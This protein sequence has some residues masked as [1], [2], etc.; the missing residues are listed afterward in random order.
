MIKLLRTQSNNQ[1][2]I[3]LV[4]YLDTELAERDGEE[5]SFYDQFNKIDQI[6]YVVIAYKNG[7]SLGCGAIKPYRAGTMEIKR[8]FVLNHNRG[9]GIASKILSELENWA[10]ELSYKT[11]ILETGKKQPEAIRLYQKNGYHIIANYPPY[12]NT[13]NSLCFKKHLIK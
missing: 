12:E 5:H 10:R 8:M 3:E 7:Q 2:F 11:C 9:Q 4:K 13:D 6:N 1:D